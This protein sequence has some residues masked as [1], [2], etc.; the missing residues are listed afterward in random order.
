[1]YIKDNLTLHLSTEGLTQ[2]RQVFLL[3]CLRSKFINRM[4]DQ[5]RLDRRRR[6]IT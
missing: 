6:T 2:Q 5:R 3:L 4:H 1:M